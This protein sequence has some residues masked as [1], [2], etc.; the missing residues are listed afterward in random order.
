M[1]DGED[2]SE[3]PS[4]KRLRETLEKGQVPFS[5]EITALASVTAILAVFMLLLPSFVVDLT[6]VLQSVFANLR[7]WPLDTPSDAQH[8]LKLVFF[9]VI[10]GLAPVIL[11]LMLAG[12]LSSLAQ[13]QPRF[14]LSRIAPNFS[15]ISPA[16]GAKRLFGKQALVEL[17]KS[18]V[19]FGAAAIISAIVVAKWKDVVLGLH[20]KAIIGIPAIISEISINVLATL[21]VFVLILAV[22]DFFYEKNKWFDDIRMTKQEV[23]EE[24]KQSEGDPHIKQKTRSVA[25]SRA[26]TR[27]MQQVPEATVVIA[28]PTHFAVAL[29]YQFGEDRVPKVLAKGQDLLALKIRQIAEENGVRVIEDKPLARAL[30]KAVTVNA[31]LPVEFYVPVAA[32]IRNVMAAEKRLAN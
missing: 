26:R 1:S 21:I 18:L 2:K 32:I 14:V 6:R 15:K 19:K 13:N 24:H 29:R 28:N 20:Q 5:R 31:E 25:R 16:N 17:A 12:L 9:A 7:E 23:K 30:Y 22:A 4:E 27:M 10:L 8:L 11:P 3:D